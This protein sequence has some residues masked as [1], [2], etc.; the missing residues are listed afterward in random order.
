M[1][2][3]LVTSP[4]GRSPALPGGADLRPALVYLGRLG[5]ARSRR[6]M[7][8][9]LDRLVRLIRTDDQQTVLTYPWPE[10]RYERTQ[11]IRTKLAE[12]M[13]PASANLSLSALRGVLRECW[14]LG[15]MD[16]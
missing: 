1:T 15:L 14:R 16:A 13:T 4:A 7:A 8:G 2:T 11:L 3:A 5:T 12:H 6:T 9:V 10:L